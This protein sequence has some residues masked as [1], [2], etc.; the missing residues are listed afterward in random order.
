MEV[1]GLQFNSSPAYILGCVGIRC[2]F[3]KDLPDDE[4]AGQHGEY[5]LYDVWILYQIYIQVILTSILIL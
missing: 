1:L 5:V 4:K 3:C 2:V